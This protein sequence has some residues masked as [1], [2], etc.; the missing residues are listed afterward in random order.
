M[1]QSNV[2]LLLPARGRQ[3]AYIIFGL[4]SLGVGAAQVGYSSID[5]GWPVWLKV[6]VSVVGFLSIPFSAIAA[7]NVST[8]N[9][10]RVIEGELGQADA[11]GIHQGFGD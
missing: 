1:P 9:P 6:A 8:D 2:L 10:P 3:A 5:L 7:S 4:A 11:E